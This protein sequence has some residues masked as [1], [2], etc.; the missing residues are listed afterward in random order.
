N[1]PGKS[2]NTDGVDA[3]SDATPK[4]PE[5]QTAVRNTTPVKQFDKES[6]AQRLRPAAP[7]DMTEAPTEVRANSSAPS[8]LGSI[9]SGA[10]SAPA[11]PARPAPARPADTS[12]SAANNNSG[13]QI[14]QAEST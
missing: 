13:G 14:T 11:A 1:T 3:T 6:L 5:E 12:A 4:P 9:M 2:Q 8:S 7:V 10:V